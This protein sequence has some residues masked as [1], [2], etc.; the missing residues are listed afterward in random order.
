MIVVDA[1]VV[2][3]LLT[4]E[5]GSDLAVLRVARETERTAPDWLHAE[6]ASA[7]SKKVRYAGLPI[8]QARQSLAAVSSIIPDM[9]SSFGLLEAAMALSIELR[10]AFY[11][12]LYLTLAVER[13]CVMITADRKFFETVAATSYRERIELLA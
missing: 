13:R 3:K 8:V 2:I 11:D 4:E 5:K 9:I 12:C 6:I 1:S 7:L 10:H